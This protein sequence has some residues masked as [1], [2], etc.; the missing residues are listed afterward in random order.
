MT[1]TLRQPTLRPA[2]A[3]DALCLG[4]LAMQVF[5]DTYATDGIRPPIAREALDRIGAL[6]DIEREITGQPV[7]IRLA[8]R[9]K[10]SVPKVDA[11]FAWSESQLALIPGKGDLA[12]AFRYGLSR[13]ASF[14]LFLEDG[15]VAIDNNPAERALRP[16]GIGRKNWLFSDVPEGAEASAFY[17]SLIQTFKLNNLNTMDACFQFFSK[18][19]ECK[20]PDEAKSLFLKI[21]GW[22]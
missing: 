20:S 12:K 2:T 10:H 9:Q 3:D 7:D 5:L 18:L 14:S 15:R 16:I 21:L 1:D 13:R 8:A 17:F 6:Y 11:F 4:V 19:P 22:G